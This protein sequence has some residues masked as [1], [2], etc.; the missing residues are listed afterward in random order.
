MENIPKINPSGTGVPSQDVYNA[1][2]PI[3]AKSY[4]ESILIPKISME[5]NIIRSREKTNISER[6]PMK[7]GLNKLW[8][9]IAA[10]IGFIFIIVIVIGVLSFGVYKEGL[11]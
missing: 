11:K 9:I 1:N 10:V 2:H 3:G 7:R 4:V 6:K 8:K 5:D